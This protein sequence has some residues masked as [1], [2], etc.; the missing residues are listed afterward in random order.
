MDLAT[1]TAA[2]ESSSKLSANLS[3]SSAISAK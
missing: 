1:A 3:D 2:S